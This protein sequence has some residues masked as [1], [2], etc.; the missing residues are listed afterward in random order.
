MLYYIYN[1]SY[2]TTVQILIVALSLHNKSR[3]NLH[4]VSFFIALSAINHVYLQALTFEQS[5][6]PMRHFSIHLT[7]ISLA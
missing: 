4:C 5:S 1:L 7:Y 2:S 6:S 3:D